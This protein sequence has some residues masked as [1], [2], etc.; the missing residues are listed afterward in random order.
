MRQATQGAINATKQELRTTLDA[1]Q[2]AK[3]KLAEL[4][5]AEQDLSRD[6]IA[7]GIT[8]MDAAI[9]AAHLATPKLTPIARGSFSS[10][11]QKMEI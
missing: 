10:S 7:G 1:L 4:E 5:S 2:E 6:G 11:L 9:Q 8:P 3:D